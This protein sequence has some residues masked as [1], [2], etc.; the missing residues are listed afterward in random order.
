M[1]DINKVEELNRLN[2]QVTEQS[3]NLVKLFKGA[4]DH[5]DFFQ[6]YDFRVRARD[7]VPGTQGPV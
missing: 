7:E 6:H 1:W 5:P 4:G 3:N 2:T